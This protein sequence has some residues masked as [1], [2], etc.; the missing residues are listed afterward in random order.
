MEE[1]KVL[2]ENRFNMTE[3]DLQEIFLKLAWTTISK[4]IVV[5]AAV[6]VLMNL[7]CM[8]FEIGGTWEVTLIGLLIIVFVV[9]RNLMQ[10][11]QVASAV[12]KKHRT[13]KISYPVVSTIDDTE[14]TLLEGY[15]GYPAKISL[16]SI[17]KLHETKLFCIVTT[18]E[19][20]MIFWKKDE[21]VDATYKEFFKF[22][23]PLVR[24]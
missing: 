4:L 16:K 17:R 24:L 18:K 23:R 5:I 22:F 6:S 11:R 1:I 2:F 19:G 14:I 9:I 3:K 10:A 20:H 13:S 8:L 21:F 15:S 7:G 12:F